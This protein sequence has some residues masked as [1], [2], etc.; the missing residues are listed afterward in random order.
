MKK[1][2][3]DSQQYFFKSKCEREISQRPKFERE[4]SWDKT[5]LNDKLKAKAYM[6]SK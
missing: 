5:D 4:L 6:F 3:N 2:H 1:K